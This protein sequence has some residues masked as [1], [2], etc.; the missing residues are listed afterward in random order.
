MTN[1]HKK[2]TDRQEPLPQ[3]SYDMFLLKLDDIQWRSAKCLNW[4]TVDEAQKLNDLASQLIGV[5]A[6]IEDREPEHND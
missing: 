2:Q 4:M 3:P 1:P 5:V 6:G